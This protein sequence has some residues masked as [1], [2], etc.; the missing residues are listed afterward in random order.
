M[1]S[2]LAR[3]REWSERRT[4]ESEILMMDDRQSADIGFSRNELLTLARLPQEVPARMHRMAGVFGADPE[5]LREDR[6]AYAEML[7]TCASCDA[8]RQ[9]KRELGGGRPTDAARCSFCPNA[10][11]FRAPVAA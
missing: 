1:M 7:M 4:R 9:C 3:L 10:E 8:Q 11:A 5:D 6:A 2:F